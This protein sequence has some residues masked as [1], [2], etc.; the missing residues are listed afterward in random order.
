MVPGQ[1]ARGI[2]PA[3]ILLPR[4]ERP[5]LHD[6]HRGGKPWGLIIPPVEPDLLAWAKGRAYRMAGVWGR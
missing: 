3:N 1:L 6:R 4:P 5:Q 2:P